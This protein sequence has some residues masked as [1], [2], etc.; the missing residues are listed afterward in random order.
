MMIT[1]FF[2]SKPSISARSWFSV[3][4]LSSCDASGFR[5]R[6]LPSASS[7]SMKMMQGAFSCACP[8]RS[9]TLAAPTPTNISTKSDPLMLKKGTFASPATAF[10]RRV[11]PVPGA[12]TRRMPF[13]ILPPIFRNFC[14]VLKNSMIS[15]SSSLASSTPATSSKVTFISF[16]P[17]ILLRLLPKLSTLEGAPPILLIRRFQMTM[18]MTKGRIQEMIPLKS[19]FSYWPLNLTL[20]FCRSLTRSGSSTLAV[21]NFTALPSSCFGVPWM[22]SLLMTRS[23]TSPFAKSCLNSL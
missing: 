4:S 16:C 6:A 7:S 1:P 12:P 20:L 18:M 13:G 23:L 3:C 17:N 19:L 9:L 5:P 22:L 21:M 14:G 8:K 2:V 15:F 10:A 11:F